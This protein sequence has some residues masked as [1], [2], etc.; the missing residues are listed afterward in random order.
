MSHGVLPPLIINVDCR[1]QSCIL[2]VDLA[3]SRLGLLFALR[4]AQE[5]NVWLVRTLWEI[6]D[7]SQ[8]YVDNP[9][10]LLGHIRHEARPPYAIAEVEHDE[11]RTSLNQWQAARLE[12]DLAGLRMYWAGDANQES[13]LPEDCDKQM[14]FRFETLA[15]ELDAR[16]DVVK[17]L[18]FTGQPQL[19][20]ARDA[21]ALA[22][23]LVR[24]RPVIFTRCLG[25]PQ[26]RRREPL[27]CRFL[28]RCEIPCHEVGDDDR[29]SQVE[30]VWQPLFHRAGVAELCWAGLEIAVVHLIVPGALA[31]QADGE[32]G[33]AGDRTGGWW[34]G[35][36][37][38]W[39]PLGGE[40]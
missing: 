2:D 25:A 15:A 20:F 16:D 35:A 10:R 6:L 1:R 26:Q 4:V 30:A 12:T 14:I 11:L 24:Y 34:H 22:A 19:D 13:L 27:L 36:G 38:F 5:M 28:R 18:G 9:G 7:N 17:R 23:A 31:M 8:F 32:W 40:A 37:A 33:A 3:F 29:E 39:Y 21:V